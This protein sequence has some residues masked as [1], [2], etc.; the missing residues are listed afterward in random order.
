MIDLYQRLNI[1][2]KSSDSDDIRTAI[3]TCPDDRI[4]H[5]AEH[6]LLEPK[7]RQFYDLNHQVLTT[8]SQIRANLDIPKSPQWKALQLDDFD[9]V[10]DPASQHTPFADLTDM[11]GDVGMMNEEQATY[12]GSTVVDGGPLR[13]GGSVDWARFSIVGVVFALIG[14]VVVT[15]ASLLGGAAEELPAHGYVQRHV[16]RDGQCEATITA[17]EQG[18]VFI[19]FCD[20]GTGQCIVSVL[21]REGLDS[22]VE[23]PQGTYDIRFSVGE[24]R[25]WNGYG[26]DRE[27][28]VLNTQT[29]VF[30]DGGKATIPTQP[31]QKSDD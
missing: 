10:V 20:S 27:L 26:F 29:M 5:A 25:E 3:A 13:S 12:S 16:E 15:L 4:A 1:E 30:R 6:I 21:V 19:E 11:L 28:R 18:N 23:I 9:L 14:I 2:R 8:I 31:I 22:V 17:S 7:R 24:R